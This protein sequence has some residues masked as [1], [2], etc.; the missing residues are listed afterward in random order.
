MPAVFR[1]IAFMRL[2]FEYKLNPITTADMARVMASVIHG[3]RRSRL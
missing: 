1:V 3:G 2:C